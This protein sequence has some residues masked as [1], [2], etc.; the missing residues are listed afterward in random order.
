MKC[1]RARMFRA[2]VATTVAAGTLWLG[3]A[4]AG[5]SHGAA[6]DQTAAESGLLV[7]TDFTTDWSEEPSAADATTTLQKA[8]KRGAPRAAS[9]P[10]A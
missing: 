10:R 7:Q 1:T 9:T 6:A 5:A 3:P 4:V 2:A 8:A